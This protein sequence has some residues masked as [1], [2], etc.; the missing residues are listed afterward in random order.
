MDTKCQGSRAKRGVLQKVSKFLVLALVIVV[1]P[2]VLAGCQ[3]SRSGNWRTLQ[4]ANE[5]ATVTRWQFADFGQTYGHNRYVNYV[6]IN[7]VVTWSGDTSTATYSIDHFAIHTDLVATN[8]LVGVIHKREG[9]PDVTR[10][11]T[12]VALLYNAPS[13]QG[14]PVGS[15]ITFMTTTTDIVVDIDKDLVL[16]VTLTLANGQ[17]NTREFIFPLSR[18]NFS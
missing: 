14:S 5:T 8:S 3:M 7:R 15:R 4:L 17:T 9:R 1:V 2:V 18:G 11:N 12:S 10:S 16:A 13:S 6:R